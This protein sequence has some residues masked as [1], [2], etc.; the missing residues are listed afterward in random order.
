MQYRIT[1]FNRKKKFLCSDITTIIS[2]FIVL[3]NQIVS[4]YF[5][6]SSFPPPVAGILFKIPLS[7]LKSQNCQ[8]FRLTKTYCPG[9]TL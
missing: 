8:Q 7:L 1:S 9:K 3:G 4:S 6:E 2:R 5:V